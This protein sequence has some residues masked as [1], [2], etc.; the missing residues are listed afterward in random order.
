MRKL[1]GFISGDHR[2][3]LLVAFLV[4]CWVGAVPSPARG[5][6]VLPLGTPVTA[7]IPATTDVYY[8][9][10]T[11]VDGAVTLTVLPPTGQN[12]MLGF[13]TPDKTIGAHGDASGTQFSVTV[14]NLK[15]GTYYAQLFAYIQSAQVTLSAT[16][17]AAPLTA[18]SEPNSFATALPLTSETKVTGHLGYDGYTTT[19]PYDGDD[20]YQI[21][22]PAGEAI[23]VTLNVSAANAN[24]ALQLFDSKQANQA[25]KDIILPATQTKIHMVEPTGGIYYV[26][27]HQYGWGHSSYDLTATVSGSTGGKDGGVA[28]SGSTG[29]KDGGVADSGSTGG[30]DAAGSGSSGASGC[31][32]SVVQGSD[33]HLSVFL[34]V[35]AL[36]LVGLQRRRRT[37]GHR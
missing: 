29:G 21:A 32:V 34:G 12:V 2:R 13:A 20:Y 28:D 36:G 23:D 19:N 9:F 11:S 22:V 25:S 15:A 14:D 24:A 33:R 17:Q 7:T 1:I 27:V 4:A 31:S 18:D 5:D 26:V 16:F 10:T 8:A 3:G 37:G 6:G 35:L 30:K